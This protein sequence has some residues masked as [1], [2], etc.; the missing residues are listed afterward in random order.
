MKEHFE[1]IEFSTKLD[2]DETKFCLFYCLVTEF[3][4]YNNKKNNATTAKNCSAQ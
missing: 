4:N 2:Y 1:L 3:N